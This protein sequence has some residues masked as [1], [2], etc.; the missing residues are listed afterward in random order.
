MW[1]ECGV[2][3]RVRVLQASRLPIYATPCPAYQLCIS[4][5]IKR[6]WRLVAAS[7]STASMKACNNS[8][9]SPSPANCDAV[10]VDWDGGGAF[11]LTDMSMTRTWPESASKA[12]LRSICPSIVLALRNL[13]RLRVQE[14]TQR[15]YLFFFDSIPRGKPR[16]KVL[17]FIRKT[18]R[19]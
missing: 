10:F 7:Q 2:R 6:T 15:N 5:F 9:L 14:P 16:K 3:V 17:I 18:R 19:N 1:C 4:L 11:S 13:A 8:S 12:S